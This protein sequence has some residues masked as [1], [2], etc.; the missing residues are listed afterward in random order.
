MN[1]IILK[2]NRFALTVFLPLRRQDA[3]L[4]VIVFEFFA[5]SRL[6]G[7]MIVQNGTKI[8]N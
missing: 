3:K 8:T 2:H 5:P 4:Y 6:S 7:K 1:W